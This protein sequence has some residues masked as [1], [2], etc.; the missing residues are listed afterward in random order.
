MRSLL[1]GGKQLFG[2]VSRA[3][4]GIADGV[5]GRSVLKICLPLE[6]CSMPRS[7]FGQRDWPLPRAYTAL[8]IFSALRGHGESRESLLPEG[9]A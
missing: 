3:A 7:F 8:R 5:R 2:K 9:A 1:A 6:P 4:S